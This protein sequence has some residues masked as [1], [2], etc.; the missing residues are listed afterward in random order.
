VATKTFQGVVQIGLGQEVEQ[1]RD[2]LLEING[3][4]TSQNNN[5][6]TGIYKHNSLDKAMM[7]QDRKGSSKRPC[8]KKGLGP[9]AIYCIPSFVPEFQNLL[10]LH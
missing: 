10:A 4:V 3:G 1:C 5:H 8:E 7:A 9:R 6:Y 2:S